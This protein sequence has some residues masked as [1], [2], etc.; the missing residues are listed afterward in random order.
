MA[1]IS[2]NGDERVGLAVAVVLHAAVL[3]VLLLRPPAVETIPKPERIQV[4]LSDNVGLTSTSPTP[5]ADPAPDIAPELGERLAD[6]VPL[7]AIVDALPLPIPETVTRPAPAPRPE[8]RPAPRTTS[9]PT[10]RQTAA[11]A[12]RQTSAPAPR[13][14][15]APAEKSGGSRV[16]SNFLDGASG[17]EGSSRNAPAAT[18]GPRVQSSLA[19]AITRQLK[20]HW[21]APQGAEAELLVTV[22][23][24]NLNRD[25]SLSG[26]PSVVRQ[27]GVTPANEAQKERHAEQAIRAVR[28]AA[29]FNLPEEYYDGWKTVTS[30]FDRRL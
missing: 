4:T 14:T 29:P 10:P 3:G 24:F 18:I 11:P 9:R 17:S 8:P 5:Y 20:P 19:S 23:R 2:L 16:G 6:S 27:S 28:L 30:Q 25:G 12:P 26:S 13:R 22:V 7:P 15:S 1:A 21:T